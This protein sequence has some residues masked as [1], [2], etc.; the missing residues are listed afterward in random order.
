MNAQVF[1][2]KKVTDEDSSSHAAAWPASETKRSEVPNGPTSKRAAFGHA[3]S[4][5]NDDPLSDR[6]ALA[7][8]KLLTQRGAED[9]IKPLFGSEAPAWT[10]HKLL[11]CTR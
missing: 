1:P 4:P 7:I 5:P 11:A 10:P 9:A 2:K 3:V 6:D 8:K